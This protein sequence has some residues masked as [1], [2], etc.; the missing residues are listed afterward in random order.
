ME[1]WDEQDSDI[2][3]DFS[4]AEEPTSPLA[5]H[6]INRDEQ[7]VIWWVLVFTCLLE[8]LHSL[9]SRGITWVLQFFSR[10][11]LFL[12]RY[13]NSIGNIAHAFPSTLYQCNNFIQECLSLPSVHRY[14]VCKACFSLS[15]FDACLEKR[16]SV[17]YIK[18]GSTCA[19]DRKTVALMREVTTRSGNKKHYPYLVYPFVS[20]VSSLQSLLLRPE[21]YDMCES[22]R[23]RLNCDTILSDVYDL[24]Y[25]TG[26]YGKTSIRRPTFHQLVSCLTLI[27]FN[28]TNT[29]YIPLV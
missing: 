27:G 13:S 29:E 23:H 8:T 12:S 18:H 15:G 6:D 21:F 7:S 4:L 2:D 26:V 25:M 14:V 1:Y 10:L 24:M 22:W 20:V 9:P 28:P 19:N 17:T 11:L 16:G 3:E 5:T